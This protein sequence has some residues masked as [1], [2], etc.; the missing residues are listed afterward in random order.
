MLR[1]VCLFICGICVIVS[2]AFAA[3]MVQ[4]NWEGVFKSKGWK[5]TPISAKIV[6]EGQDKYRAIFDVKSKEGKTASVTAHAVIVKGKAAIDAEVDLG[7]GLGGP[8]KLKAKIAEGEMTGKFAGSGAPGAFTMKRI[9]KGSPTLGAKPPQ[10][11]VV[12]FDGKNLDAWKCSETPWAIVEG[13]VM[14]VRK[15]NI[16]TKQEFGD[17]KLHVE[18]RTPLMANMRGQARG[19]SGVYVLGR[20]EVQVLDSYGLETKENECGGIYKMATPKVNACLPPT[21]WQTYDITFHAPQY[22]ASGVKTKSATISVE[23]NGILIH[24]NVE[25]NGVTGGAISPDEGK[26]GPLL[27]QDHHCLV[28][29][30]NIWVQPL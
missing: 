29:Y 11:A 15:G 13:G 2:T 14:E 16:C 19:N 25:L 27:L 28:Q 10:G 6:A 5:D 21:E 30:R 1:N 3:D 4:G 24:D 18:F 23:Q 8:C 7:P 26:T 9:E 22:N 17:Q 20:W 12:L